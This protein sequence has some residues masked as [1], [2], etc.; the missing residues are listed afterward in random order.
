MSRLD[1]CLTIVAPRAL[2]EELVDLLLE[3]PQWV[4]KFTVIPAEGRDATVPLAA[5]AE[6]VKGRG[7]EIVVQC[8]VNAEDAAL[9]V[10]A[11]KQHLGAP[12]VAYWLVPVLS[13]GRL[14]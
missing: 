3:Y 13:L 14:A 1:A 11:M 8:L 4:P 7:R 10:A 2:E 5:I 12:A 6:R 9:L